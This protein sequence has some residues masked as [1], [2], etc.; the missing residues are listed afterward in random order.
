M[1]GKSSKSGSEQGAEI[2]QASLQK[3]TAAVERLLAA[4]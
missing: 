1:G 3:D 4:G 2:V